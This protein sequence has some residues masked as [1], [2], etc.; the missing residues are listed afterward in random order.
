MLAPTYGRRT[1]EMHAPLQLCR[2]VLHVPVGRTAE[3]M[4]HAAHMHVCF[5]SIIYDER[6]CEGAY[7]FLCVQKSVDECVPLHSST[8]V[9]RV[10]RSNK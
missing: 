4:F 3:Y 7:I 5:I 9:A 2:S 8:Q 1:G 10:S 6:A